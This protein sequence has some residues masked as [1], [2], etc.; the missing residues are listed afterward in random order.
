MTRATSSTLPAASEKHLSSYASAAL[1]GIGVLSG[2]QVAD[3]QIVT[4]TDGGLT[5]VGNGTISFF[6]GAGFA[7]DSGPELTLV[8][9]NGPSSHS[10]G[11]RAGVVNLHP[12]NSNN[13]SI[14]GGGYFAANLAKGAAIGSRAGSFVGSGNE[15]IGFCAAT[16]FRT[17]DEGNF[18]G[19]PPGYLG[20]SFTDPHNSAQTDYGWAEIS[21]S[22]HQNTLTLVNAAYNESGGP[23]M[24]GEVPEPGSLALLASGAGCLAAWR[25]RSRQRQPAAAAAPAC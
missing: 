17:E 1:V 13:P 4:T 22:S 11:R 25:L 5:I 18:F 9:S 21:E 6:A 14:F 3:A 8:S 20:F 24:A 10:Y 23:I 19:E 12:L 2:A 15:R 7:A 16:A